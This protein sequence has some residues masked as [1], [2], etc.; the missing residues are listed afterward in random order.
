[1]TM[2]L[3]EILASDEFE[4][5]STGRMRLIVRREGADSIARALTTAENC[6][7]VQRMER[8]ALRSFAW[9]SGREGLVRVC[10]RGGCVA[11]LV[12]DNYLFVNRPGR[13]FEAHWRVERL[14]LPVPRILGVLWERHGP[15]VSG[16]LATEHLPGP[17]LLAWLHGH[18]S[19][20]SDPKRAEMMENVGA[21]VRE[22]H[23]R[24]VWHADL[25]I[26]NIVIANGVPHVID[27]DR[28]VVGAVPGRIQC[29]RNLLRFR[30]SLQKNA[31][32]TG[33]FGLFLSGYGHS[34]GFAIPI[35]LDLAYQL[36][37]WFSES[38]Q[39]RKTQL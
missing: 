29:S 10:H 33:C 23:R 25:Q 22:M 8:G 7:P 35:W 17:D 24:G 36:R 31:M 6:T 27:L 19:G 2:G 4:M 1:M 20:E 28:A 34:G 39:G 32:P 15:W 14:G 12:R 38:M 37:G 9:T 5:R 18:G 30:R 11:R 16:A 3:S 21:M 13:E 26:K